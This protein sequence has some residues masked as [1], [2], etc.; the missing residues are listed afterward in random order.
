[1]SPRPSRAYLASLDP[2]TLRELAALIERRRGGRG[3]DDPVA[4]AEEIAEM[5]ER[6]TVPALGWYRRHL[7]APRDE[8]S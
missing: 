7:L 2:A 3:F 1:M 4:A 8:P 6:G 5:L